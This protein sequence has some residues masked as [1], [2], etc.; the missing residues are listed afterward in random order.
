MH[1]QITIKKLIPQ[2]FLTQ[3]SHTRSKIQ[4][5]SQD[6]RTLLFQ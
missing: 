1:Y 3:T 2:T 4:Y 5:K 6:N